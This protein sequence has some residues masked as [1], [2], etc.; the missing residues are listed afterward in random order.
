MPEHRFHK[1]AEAIAAWNTRAAESQR[2][3]MLV[4]D[5]LES[6]K[7]LR[8]VLYLTTRWAHTCVK[9]DC[10]FC[11]KRRLVLENADA[12]LTARA[13]P[14]SDDFEAY[15]DRINEDRETW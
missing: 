15:Y 5:A 9:S 13:K 10:P 3:K 4:S 1:E 6:I 12:L 8:D 11:A 14:V 7:K 2:L